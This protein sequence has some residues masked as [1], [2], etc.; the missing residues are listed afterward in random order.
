MIIA[1][2]TGLLR[3][4]FVAGPLA[5]SPPSVEEADENNVLD[6]RNLPDN[7]AT[8]RIKAWSGMAYRDHVYLTVSTFT[9]GLPINQSSVGKDVLFYDIPKALFSA[10]QGGT[11]EVGYRVEFSA[12]DNDS[13]TTTLH[14]IGGF[15]QAATLDL[16][17]THYLSI[18]GFPPSDIPKQARMQR[19][20]DWGRAPYVYT[21]SDPD[22]A[23]VVDTGEVTALANGSCRITATDSEGQTQSYPLTITGMR[24]VHFLSASCDWQGMQDA[25]TTA[26]LVPVPLADFRRLWQIYYPDNWPVTQYTGWLP[27]AF[28]TADALG[29][30][31]A[32]AYDL[33]GDDANANASS[34]T[35]DTHLQALGLAT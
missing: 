11:L 19:P 21:S 27:Y 5:L 1:W 6:P 14:I 23:T 18:A 35:S 30:G 20:A 25:C 3:K 8:V 34:H 17:G 32:W 29:A 28:W 2:I 4:L 9:D 26:G 10:A 24:V 31:T 16:N 22:I 33:D 13:A 12:G 15:D 7:G